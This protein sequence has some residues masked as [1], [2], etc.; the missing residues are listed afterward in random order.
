MWEDIARRQRAFA[1]R[2][3]LAGHLVLEVLVVWLA[4]R[5]FIPA[6]DTRGTLDI[7][8]DEQFLHG[9]GSFSVV[10]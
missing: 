4:G 9:D 3:N 5:C 6:G 7:R 8:A 1:R 2:G 10:L